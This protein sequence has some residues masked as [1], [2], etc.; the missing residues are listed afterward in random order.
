M[1]PN[2]LMEKN[3]L[4]EQ[5]PRSTKRWFLLLSYTCTCTLCP[6]NRYALDCGLKCHT[7]KQESI[8]PVAIYKDKTLHYIFYSLFC[9]TQLLHVWIKSHTCYSVFMAFEMS[10]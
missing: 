6:T 5:H 1:L 9:I 3:Q 8:D 10:F 7:I 4:K 2:V